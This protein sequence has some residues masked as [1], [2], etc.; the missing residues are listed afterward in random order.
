MAI[1]RQ[2]FLAVI[3]ISLLGSVEKCFP[4][5]TVRMQRYLAFAR[6]AWEAL[7]YIVFD[8]QKYAGIEDCVVCYGSTGEEVRHLSRRRF[9]G[10]S[11]FDLNVVCVS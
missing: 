6:Y 10:L 9:P 4:H 11:D 8:G 5:Q 1:P 2:E 3:E 7:A